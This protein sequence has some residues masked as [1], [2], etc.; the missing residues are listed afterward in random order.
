MSTW[1]EGGPAKVRYNRT[2]SGWFDSV[3][4]EDWFFTVVDVA[5]HSSLKI[6]WRA[7]LS[8]WKLGHGKNNPTLPRDLFPHQLRKLLESM[9]DCIQTN[10]LSGF[11]KCGI[12][13]LDRNQVLGR[14]PRGAGDQQQEES[15]NRISEAFLHN[16][17]ALRY[18]ENDPVTKRRKMVNVE[19]GKSITS[20]DFVNY[21]DNPAEPVPGPSNGDAEKD[22]RMASEAVGESDD[23]IDSASS[24]TSHWL[25][26]FPITGYTTHFL[27]YLGP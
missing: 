16:L 23:A 19:A 9:G 27:T 25:E 2:K 7:V 14:L 22:D 21:R 24:P 12:C 15:A 26:G 3:T 4:F 13:P 17:N 11:C 10:I 6:H 20:S 5:V 8:K 1:T 18:P